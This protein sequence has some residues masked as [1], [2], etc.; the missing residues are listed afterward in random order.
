[1]V[2]VVVQKRL[3]RLRT[4]ARGEQRALRA[5][6]V[7]SDEIEVGDPPRSIGVQTAQL[8]P[9]HEQERPVVGLAYARE[10]RLRGERTRSSRALLPPEPLG[11]GFPAQAKS[12][13]CERAET[14][15]ADELGLEPLDHAVDPVPQS[16]GGH[17]LELSRARGCKTL[18]L[19]RVLVTGASGLI[20]GVLWTGLSGEH[21]LSGIDLRRDRHRGIG[22]GN[23]RRP[24]SI[25]RAFRGVEAVVDLATGAAVDLPWYEVEKDIRGRVNVLEAARAHGVR[26]Y[27]FASSNHVTGLYELDP[28]YASIVAG[29]YEGV[30]PAAIP[31]IGPEWP[32]RPDSPYGVG[33]AFAEIASRHYAERYGMACVCLRIGTVRRDDRPHAVRDYATLL[34]HSDLVRLVDCALRAPPTVRHGVYYGVSANR[35]RFWDIA[36]AREEL[37][38]EPHDDAERFRRDAPA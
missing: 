29:A 32:V 10:H 6:G 31:L 38:F 21:A 11:D 33:K 27:I 23:V 24:R 5:F 9:L 20:G 17:G 1:M 7:S 28:P 37:G 30:D 18:V 25:Q 16:V 26:R 8:G 35:W 13:T 22:R 12:A 14:V 34:T 4:P 2:Q 19:V 15:L 36:N 3:V